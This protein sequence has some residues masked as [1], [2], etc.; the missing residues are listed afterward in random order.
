VTEWKAAGKYLAFVTLTVPHSEHSKPFELVDKLLACAE[1]LN[2]GRNRIAALVPCMVGQVRALE[3]T[4]GD[5]GWHPH[6]HLLLFLE[7]K[8]DL[9]DI[10]VKL[11]KRWEALVRKSGLG[12]AKIGAFKVQDGSEA[13]KYAS[14]WG[15][16]EEMTKGHQKTARSKRGRTPFAL[17][18][19]F[20]RGDHQ[21]GALFREFAAMFKG[22]RQLRWSKGLRALLAIGEEKT[23]E[24]EAATVDAIDE[25]LATISDF[26]W[27]IILRHNLRAIVLELFRA[28]TRKDFENMIYAYSTPSP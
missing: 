21:A 6:L 25:K 11:W 17:L 1:R 9:A 2:S 3:V 22:R 7:Q 8:P 20:A 15:I 5:H 4:Q 10:H 28:G 18:G 14:K 13:A 16:P 24:Q 19:D 26:E 23:D 12:T 27:S